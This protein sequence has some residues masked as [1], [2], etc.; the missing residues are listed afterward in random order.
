MFDKSDDS[1]GSDVKVKSRAEREEL[2][3]KIRFLEMR[4]A[5]IEQK[6]H[7][8]ATELREVRADLAEASEALKLI[9][10]ES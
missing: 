2:L 5:E 7:G 8:N 4:V 3:K 1:D 10:E 9:K 6:L